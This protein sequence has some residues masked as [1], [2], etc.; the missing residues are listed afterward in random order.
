MQGFES[1]FCSQGLADEEPKHGFQ[2]T[3]AAPPF[4]QTAQQGLKSWEQLGSRE[5]APFVLLPPRRRKGLAKLLHWTGDS[6]GRITQ[7]NASLSWG[8]CQNWIRPFACFA[9]GT[10]TARAG[11]QPLNLRFAMSSG[12]GRLRV[13]LGRNWT[14]LWS[15]VMSSPSHAFVRPTGSLRGAGY[16]F[17][18]RCASTGKT[19]G[20][21]SDF[22]I[23]RCAGT[24]LFPNQQAK[25]YSGPRELQSEN[26]LALLL[27]RLNA[28]PF[29]LRTALLHT[30]AF[31]EQSS[32]LDSR[33]SEI[34]TIQAK[35]PGGPKG[36][37]VVSQW[38]S[39]F[40][41]ACR[42][43]PCG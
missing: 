3:G 13:R 27:V 35:C 4:R 23:F 40:R 18:C 1:S 41:W 32:P 29:A 12:A 34:C 30:R 16:F 20:A 6:F 25:V 2:I 36:V 10:L 39:V 37:S 9:T 24:Q 42:C 14:C 28:D 17:G 26:C 21:D 43:C 19:T 8:G 5:L 22:C 7:T 11:S 31:S 38:F 33:Q 15:G